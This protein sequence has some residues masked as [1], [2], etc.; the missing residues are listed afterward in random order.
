MPSVHT[1]S[2]SLTYEIKRPPLH[3]RRQYKHS[4]KGL[5]VRESCGLTAVYKTKNDL[6]CVVGGGFDP[7]VFMPNNP[8][9]R[10]A[11]EG[12]DRR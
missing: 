1:P 10:R 2:Q 12:S 4:K 5:N 6:V 8:P 7:R 3:H 11:S 9:T